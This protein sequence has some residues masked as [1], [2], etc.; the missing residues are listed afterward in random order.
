MHGNILELELEYIQSLLPADIKGV[1]SSGK[2]EI[3]IL[4]KGENYKGYLSIRLDPS[5][6]NI[7]ASGPCGG[8]FIENSNINRLHRFI[9]GHNITGITSVPDE[10][11]FYINLKKERPLKLF[12]SLIPQKLN[13]LL[14]DES[15]IIVWANRY[16][17][18]DV[19][20]VPILEGIVFLK[21][22]F[23]SKKENKKERCRAS[24][25]PL[26]YSNIL[27]HEQQKR[28][29]DF[30]RSQDHAAG[31]KEIIF[32]LYFGPFRLA[33]EIRPVIL[34]FQIP[35][36]E[37]LYSGNLN[38]ILQESQ[39]LILKY[40]NAKKH[41]REKLKRLKKDIHRLD[42]KRA[43]IEQ[44]YRTA[45]NHRKFTLFGEL[46]K[47]N[48]KC[49]KP[50]Q[51]RAVLKGFDGRQYE[52]PLDEKLSAVDNMNN[53]FQ[54]AKRMK[55]GIDI[56]KENLDIT[57]KEINMLSSELN[58]LEMIDSYQGLENF[59][60]NEAKLPSEDKKPGNQ[61]R[62]KYPNI[63]EYTTPEGYTILVA[64]NS[65]ANDELTLRIAKPN[66]MWLHTQN[67][68]GSH[69]IIK[70]PDKGRSIPLEVLLQ[71]ARLAVK[72]SRAKNSSKVPVDYTQKKYVKKPKRSAPGFVIYTNQKTL[73]IES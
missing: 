21:N 3:S 1:Y 26:C 64:N 30:F 29:L 57:E 20:N 23:L 71:A 15:G 34:P 17:A 5:F 52:I 31:R 24:D 9:L 33:G 50:S 55:R 25:L 35:D 62:P 59:R 10:R 19:D 32:Y 22:D 63:R 45:R 8:R 4:I 27:S 41:L 48:L 18:M 13:A 61:K 12:I 47:A 7:H 44:E 51:K 69:V 42:R 6:P 70:N 53:Y 16:K 56:K 65:R 38:S 72:N 43:L 36:Q 58:R 14:L 11:Y 46:I 49:I 39:S 66:D 67:I 60:K 40:V 73:I 37:Y 68:P 54:Y 28:L 2:N